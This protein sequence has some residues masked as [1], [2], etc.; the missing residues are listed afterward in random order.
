MDSRC[1]LGLR[2]ATAASNSLFN[3]K[4][5]EST[6]MR[7]PPDTFTLETLLAPAAATHSSLFA[8]CSPQKRRIRSWFSI[9]CVLFF[10]SWQKNGTPSPFLSI[11]ST[12]FCK[13]AGGVGPRKYAHQSAS[14]R[15]ATRS[16]GAPNTDQA[17]EPDL[18]AARHSPLCLYFVTSLLRPFTRRNLISRLIILW[19]RDTEPILAAWVYT[20]VSGFVFGALA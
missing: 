16:N 2:G 20:P 4:A 7:R 14:P 3:R 11:T 1:N 17:S 18:V 10:H 6:E 15:P 8:L 5:G 9:T 12:L 19:R 13:S